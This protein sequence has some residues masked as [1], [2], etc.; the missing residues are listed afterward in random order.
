MFNFLFLFIFLKLSTDKDHFEYQK[1]LNMTLN[2]KIS[3][4]GFTGNAFYFLIRSLIYL[5]RFRDIYIT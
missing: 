2:Q 3:F 5:S 4:T 1:V